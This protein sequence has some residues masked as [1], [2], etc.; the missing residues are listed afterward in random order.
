M[1]DEDLPNPKIIEFRDYAGRFL[2]SEPFVYSKLF[3]PG[4][5]VVEHGKQFIVHRAAVADDVLHVNFQ[6]GQTITAC[7]LDGLAATSHKEPGR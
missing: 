4:N 7:R 3:S 1:T 5:M 2:W 6:K